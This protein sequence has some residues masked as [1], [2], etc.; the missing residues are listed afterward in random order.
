MAAEPL[1][2]EPL[3]SGG[4]DGIWPEPPDGNG[5]MLEPAPDAPPVGGNALLPPLGW[6]DEPPPEG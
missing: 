3:W 6:L 1:T 5:L 4:S 2:T